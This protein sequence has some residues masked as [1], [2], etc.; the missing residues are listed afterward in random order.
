MASGL[1]R[2]LA[3][4]SVAVLLV[5]CEDP[6]A[7]EQEPTLVESRSGPRGSTDPQAIVN[8]AARIDI[9]W[10]DN[11][12]NE[13][14]WEIH[15]STTGQNG[16]YSLRASVGAN[17]TSYA[18]EGLVPSTEYCY[19]MRSFK[20]AGRKPSYAA[21]TNPA[22]GKTLDLPAAPSNAKASPPYSSVV[23]LTWT[24]NSQTEAGFRVER[25]AG[26]AGPWTFLGI[27][28]NNA[29]SYSDFGRISEQEVCYRVFALII[30]GLSAPSNTACTTPPAPVTDL[31]A[32]S[33]DGENIDL[34]WT[35]NSAVEDGYEVQRWNGVSW[36][37]LA[38][39][40]ANATT[41]HDVL[42]ADAIP[43][44]MVL[45]KKDGGHSDGSNAATI[46]PRAPATVQAVPGSSTSVWVYW[47]DVSNNDEGFRVERS[48][49]GGLSW[50]AVYVAGPDEL[51][52]GFSEESEQ[53]V[54]YRVFAFNS[55][56]DSPPSETACTVPPAAPTNLVIVSIDDQTLEYRWHDNSAYEDGYEIW[57]F[58]SDEWGNYYYY[59][60]SLP[61]N[62][63][64]YQASSTESIYGVLARK[65]TGYSDWAFPE[66]ASA[67]LQ[68]RAG[69]PRPAPASA[70]RTPPVLKHK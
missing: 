18:D 28:A 16:T 57:F 45:A 67:A 31:K 24:D 9:I 23:D 6:V 26:P 1:M 44:Y 48:K 70:Q 50:E 63:T 12:I 65:D 35:D 40:P 30:G 54:C 66:F 5:A 59:P 17:S 49:D 41:Y 39:V 8:S 7:P 46:P 3:L 38:D 68:N 37:A 13:S 52:A 69:T 25:S 61:L 14:G 15:R 56:G 51:S 20:M 62:S 55:E 27:A 19:R 2:L 29:T 32:K 33:L 43:Y 11:A 21:F 10:T 22:C 34:T 58:G 42:P 64:I 60:V 4:S 47:S 36:A 53:K